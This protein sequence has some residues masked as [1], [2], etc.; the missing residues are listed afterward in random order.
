MSAEVLLATDGSEP[1]RRAEEFIRDHLNPDTHAVHAV[2]VITELPHP[3][4]RAD[5]NADVQTRLFEAAEN[6]L[7]ETRDRLEEVGFTVST[8]VLH[9]NPGKAITDCASERAVGSIV[10]GRRGRG[11][12]GELVLGS[13]SR[14]VVHHVDIPV[15]V[16]PA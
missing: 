8:E 11:T 6:L 7:D 12:V 10:M 2:N 3:Y 4:A 9:G 14:Y 1:A 15:T 16:V 13:V 5:V